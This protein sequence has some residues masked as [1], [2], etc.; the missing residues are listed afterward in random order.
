MKG[1]VLAD[2]KQ[3]LKYLASDWLTTNIAFFLFNIGRYLILS[4]GLHYKEG[5]FLQELPDLLLQPK[6][7][8]EQLIIPIVSL[9]IYWLSGYYAIPF[10]KSRLRELGTTVNS[11]IICTAGIYL[12]LLTNDQITHRTSNWGLILLLFLLLTVCVYAGRLAITSH[13]LKQLKKKRLSFKTLIVGNSNA[14]R[15]TASNLENSRS[16][17]GYKVCG[18]VAMPGENQAKGGVNV[19][20]ES[21]LENICR[22]LEIDQIV[23]SLEK[24]DETET[25]H[26]LYKL[27]KLDIPIRI[28]PATLSFLTSA[29]HMEDIYAEPFIDLT[30]PSVS[31]SQLAIKRTMDVVCSALALI[32]LSPLM[33]IVGMAVRKDSPGPAI[34]SQER[35]GK[36]RKPFRIYK[37]RT[38]KT[39]AETDGPQLSSSNDTRIT[40]LGAVLRKYRI[41]ELPQFWNV[42]KGDMSL[43]G[44]RP[45]RAFFIN[46]I[47]EE[48]PYYTMV[49]QVRP[50]ITSWGMVKYGY[51]S[52]LK[53]MVRRTRYDLLYLSNMSIALDIKIIIYTVKTVFRGEGL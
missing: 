51:A 14:A 1:K 25:L 26:L 16:N 4:R 40:R 5:F 42:L 48:A 52:S 31:N 32:L 28:E 17:L 49:H 45:E 6:V 8:W 43:V 39:D 23:I 46:Q 12:A 10:G 47:V 22:R 53:E 34:Y 50:G 30:R 18:F 9:G 19:Y 21:E 27:F 37:F 36:H 13:A 20:S 3:R 35:I 2:A 15:Q 41:D 24:P 33:L 29:I 7:L 44:P 11:A 38:M